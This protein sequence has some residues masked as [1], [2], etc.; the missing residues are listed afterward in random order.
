MPGGILD[1]V[2]GYL[3]KRLVLTVMFPTLVFWSALLWLIGLHVGWHHILTWWKGLA[4]VQQFLL[5]AAAIAVVVFFASLVSVQLGP[6]TR[7]YE[8]YWGTRGP[9]RWLAGAGTW[10]QRQRHARLEPGDDRDFERRYRLYPRRA[11]DLLPTRLGNVLRGA[12]LYPADEGRYGMDAVFFWP[13][14]YVVL[15]QTMRDSLQ[16][17]RASLDLMLVTSAL[18]VLYLLTAACFLGVVG[19]TSWP[20][21]LAA[22]GGGALAALAAYRGAVRAAVTYGELVRVAFD[23]YRGALLAQLGYAA[24]ASLVDERAMWENIGQQMYRRFAADPSAL[25]Y[26]ADTP[27]PDGPARGQTPTIT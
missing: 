25:R 14:L 17:A 16:D 27:A 9:G 11:E 20:L 19:T 18:G 26:A 22:V 5:V 10:V 4:G 24:P 12:E 3:D 13:R 6:L 8:G 15:S 1:K 21:W 7:L 2:V 23:L